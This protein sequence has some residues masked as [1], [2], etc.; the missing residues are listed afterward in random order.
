MFHLC[1]YGI[2]MFSQLLKAN[3][4]VKVVLFRLK[5]GWLAESCSTTN[6]TFADFDKSLQPHLASPL[7]ACLFFSLSQCQP[8]GS[9]PGSWPS[10]PGPQSSTGALPWPWQPQVLFT[11][12]H[13]QQKKSECLL[14]TLCNKGEFERIRLILFFSQSVRFH[15][16][17]K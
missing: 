14:F 1:P 4:R 8:S 10:R 9:S 7:L 15:K 5:F 13:I 17:Y 11:A 6:I 3:A 2:Y 12:T 16:D